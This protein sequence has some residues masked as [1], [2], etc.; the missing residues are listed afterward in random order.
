MCLAT[1]TVP[2]VRGDYRGGLRLVANTGAPQGRPSPSPSLRG[3]GVQVPT[4][5]TYVPSLRVLFGPMG[6]RALDR[7][8]LLWLRVEPGAGRALLIWLSKRR[9]PCRR[10]PARRVP[11]VLSDMGDTMTYPQ[12]YAHDHRLPGLQKEAGH[13]STCAPVSA[14]WGCMR[15]A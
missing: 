9:D 13:P 6:T 12:G 15:G 14:R 5:N 3:R 2:P 10:R 11:H 8:F 1:S 7:D 4:P